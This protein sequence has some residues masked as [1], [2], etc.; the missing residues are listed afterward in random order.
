MKILY[1]V[2]FFLIITPIATIIRT[3]RYISLI[4]NKNNSQKSYWNQISEN[5]DIK[6]NHV[7]IS[8]RANYSDTNHKI[9]NIRGDDN[10]DNYT[11]W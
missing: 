6:Y 8:E 1:L 3:V 5:K 7:E 11:F 4:F 9:E 2:T 10:P